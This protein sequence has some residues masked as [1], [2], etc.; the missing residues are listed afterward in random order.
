MLPT[1]TKKVN[2]K[3]FFSSL[4]IEILLFLGEGKKIP[5]IG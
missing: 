5:N 1:N 4:R 2:L 3:R